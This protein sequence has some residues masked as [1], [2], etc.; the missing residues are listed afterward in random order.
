MSL[1]GSDCEL[2]ASRGHISDLESASDSPL[3]QG[4]KQLILRTDTRGLAAAIDFDAARDRTWPRLSNTTG[5]DDGAVSPAVNALR[6]LTQ[7][8]P[9]KS[10]FESRRLRRMSSALANSFNF[11]RSRTPT[12]QSGVTS[13]S[14]SPGG[15]I[16]SGQR[17]TQRNRHAHRDTDDR[18]PTS[19][20]GKIV[21]GRLTPSSITLRKASNVNAATLPGTSMSASLHLEDE[22]LRS[23]EAAATELLAFY[24]SRNDET[25]N[26]ISSRSPT[27]GTSG[28]PFKLTQES[29]ST[30][31][32]RASMA[33]CPPTVH[34]SKVRRH[35]DLA[36][37]MLTFTDVHIAPGTFSVEADSRKQSLAATE[38]PP[39]R[40]S[41]VQFRSRNSIHE[42]IWREDETTSGSSFTSSSRTSTSP[43]RVGQSWRSGKPSPEADEGQAK[44]LP[45][46]S[47][48][49]AP[50]PSAGMEQL[51]VDLFQWSWGKTAASSDYTAQVNGRKST[52]PG[53]R[54]L[55]SASNPDFS[56]TR[57]Y[58]DPCTTIERHQRSSSEIRDIQPFPPLRDRSS[59]LEWQKAPLVDINDPL[60]GR[61]GDHGPNEVTTIYDRGRARLDS[62]DHALLHQSL[63]IRRPS[64][65]PW[66]PAR[67]EL[68]GRVG[69][70]VGSSSHVRVIY[71]QKG[72]CRRATI[73]HALLAE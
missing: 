4:R 34:F 65:H 28:S 68:S 27:P 67:N 38:P 48:H 59:T 1:A 56:R 14:G 63:S 51:P 52:R 2:C 44:E 18:C 66:A 24:S 12:V 61:W 17:I 33:T 40:I 70:S 35:S 71:K 47:M 9:T 73:E 3:A 41:V 26:L 13:G 49:N 19:R 72:P 58:S 29:S 55:T 45:E 30:N 6:S 43:R 37:N 50:V 32:R 15:D 46:V 16:D 22:N 25:P 53:L 54:R 7:P 39:R 60:A 31:E 69:S 8:Q 62:G 23:S 64:S 42:V 10:D 21:S 5:R 57:Q 11:L 36:E 20:D